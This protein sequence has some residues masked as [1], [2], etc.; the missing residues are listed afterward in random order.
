M[1]F[2]RNLLSLI[3]WLICIIVV[4]HYQGLFMNIKILYNTL[5]E[6][7]IIRIF[8]RHLYQPYLN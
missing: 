6:E 3:L 2:K 5:K 4:V 1:L 8:L 7:V